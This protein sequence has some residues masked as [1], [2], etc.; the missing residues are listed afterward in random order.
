V[1]QLTNMHAAVNYSAETGDS[2][3]QPHSI[4]PMLSESCVIGVMVM[5]LFSLGGSLRLFRCSP[6]FPSI[7]YVGRWTSG[8]RGSEPSYSYAHPSNLEA[9]QHVLADGCSRLF[10]NKYSKQHVRSTR[11]KRHELGGKDHANDP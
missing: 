4:L 7:E 9:V 6:S 3:A 5:F 2:T 8:M 10:D 1:V 11:K